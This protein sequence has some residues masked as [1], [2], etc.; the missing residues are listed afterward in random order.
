MGSSI[1]NINDIRDKIQTVLNDAN[2]T[3]ASPVDL[4]SGLYERI[5]KVCKFN[6]SDIEPQTSWFP[7]VSIH[8]DSKEITPAGIAVNQLI[9][10]RKATLSF[11][12]IGMI[13]YNL[14]SNPEDNL[15]EEEITTLMENIEL[16]LKSNATLDG[17]VLYQ[18]P[19]GVDYWTQPYSDT[20]MLR[21]GE[22][23]LEAVMHY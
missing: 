7:C 6:P 23:S 2:T 17:L 22:M 14:V 13:Y 8:I 5:N 15:P 11:K 19:T 21:V 12:I 18:V 10:S 4:S 3:T 9:S 20:D 16:I 1:L